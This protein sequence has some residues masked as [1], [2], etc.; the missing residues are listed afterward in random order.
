MKPIELKDKF[1]AHIILYCKGYYQQNNVSFHEG[2]R[3]IWAVRCG[4]SLEHIN[5]RFDEYIADE[6][7]R[8]IALTKPKRIPYLIEA[9]HKELT[10]TLLFDFEKERTAIEK[11]I[12]LYMNELMMLQVKDK[13]NKNYRTLIKLPK[14]QKR[15]FA[16]IVKGNFEYNDYY[17]VK[18]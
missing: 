4:L 7:Y 13:V 16:K 3:R 1:Q 14:P 10:K 15:L 11:L 18:Y 9:I 12:F 17:K 6:L 2:L 8:I 5:E